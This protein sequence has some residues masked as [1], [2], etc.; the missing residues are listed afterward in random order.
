MC[1]F[2]LD[3]KPRESL[4]VW[5]AVL[6]IKFMALPES[7]NIF[8]PKLLFHP[9]GRKGELQWWTVEL[10]DTDKDLGDIL[11]LLSLFLKILTTM[12]TPKVPN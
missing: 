3:S 8:V 4:D 6:V 12:P 5:S 2:A 10:R 1:S 11:V 7:L 9:V